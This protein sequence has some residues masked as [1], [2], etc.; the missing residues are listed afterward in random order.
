MNV[1]GLIRQLQEQDQ[2]ATVVWQH[3]DGSYR[4]MEPVRPAATYRYYG[5]WTPEPLCQCGKSPDFCGIHDD[6]PVRE[7]LVV[8]GGHI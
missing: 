4:D 2:D 3:R 7:E 6:R 5:I 8:V 1:R